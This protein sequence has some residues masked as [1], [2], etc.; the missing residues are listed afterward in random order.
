[1][2]GSYVFI[3]RPGFWDEQQLNKEDPMY[4]VKATILKSKKLLITEIYSH[5]VHQ[6][7]RDLWS[8]DNNAPAGY[9]VFL[10]AR[11]T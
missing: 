1:M 11:G 8:R 7:P 3:N 4:N 2:A 5:M 9:T 6:S 10:E